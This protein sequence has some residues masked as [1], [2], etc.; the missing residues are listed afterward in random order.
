MTTPETMITPEQFGS[1][2]GRGGNDF[3]AFADALTFLKDHGGGML[4]C[5]AKPYRIDSTL[6]LPSNVTFWRGGGS[7]DFSRVTQGP[8]LLAEGSEALPISLT[9]NAC[10]GDTVL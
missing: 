3:Q 6:R 9:K 1:S 2:V 4:V 7:F 8:Y 10:A 5:S